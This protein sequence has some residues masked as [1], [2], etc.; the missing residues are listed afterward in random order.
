MPSEE[1]IIEYAFD[2]NDL[3]DGVSVVMQKDENGN[4]YS[5]VC[6][7]PSQIPMMCSYDDG[8]IEMAIL[9]LGFKNWNDNKGS[10]Y[11]SF[12]S[13]EATASLQGNFYV[14]TTGWF[15]DTYW[16]GSNSYNMFGCFSTTRYIKQ[17]IDVGDST[18]VRVGF[19]SVTFETIYGETGWF[20]NSAQNVYK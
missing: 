9:H 1:P 8:S 4:T 10:L 6:E 17:G 14:K 20:S 12:E 2:I 16:S 7:D 3:K 15:P 19:S 13:D 18:E 11:F 5:Y